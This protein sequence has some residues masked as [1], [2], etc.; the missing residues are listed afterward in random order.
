LAAAW[1]EAGYRQEDE[2]E[3]GCLAEERVHG[4]NLTYHRSEERLPADEERFVLLAMNKIL[5]E[6]GLCLR[7]CYEAGRCPAR[8]NGRGRSIRSND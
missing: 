2:Y 4:G 3:R 1:R 7:T 8:W 6:R 5:I